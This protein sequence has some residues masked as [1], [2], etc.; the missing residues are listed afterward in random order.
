MKLKSDLQSKGIGFEASLILLHFGFSIMN[1]RK[2]HGDI[3]VENIAN[4]KMC[5]KIGAREEGVL[6]SHYYQNGNFRDVVLVGILKEEFYKS[7]SE[8]LKKFGL[9]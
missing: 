6:R 7:N 8:S 1:M 4:R 2:I 3:L 5:E 9:L